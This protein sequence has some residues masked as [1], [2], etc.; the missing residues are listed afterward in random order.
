SVSGTGTIS[1][2][3]LVYTNP[4]PGVGKVRLVVN[5]A[6]S[7][8]SVVQLDLVSNTTLTATG[9]AT[10]PAR[11][12]AYSAG[13]NLPLNT[14]RVEA[15]TTLL[16]AGNALNLGAAPRAVA[17]ALPTSGPTAGVLYTGVSQKIDGAGKVA[18]DVGVLPGF[19]YYSVRLKL[20]ASATVGAV[21]DGVSLD[22][23]FRAAVRGRGGDEVL[24]SA[25]FSIGK[26]EVR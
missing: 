19:V 24:S 10:I 13:M 2:H 8:A 25:D 4:Q 9:S 12:G 6:A 16:V 5:Q 20:P 3:G 17:A 11:G 14:S 26:L 1:V 22:Q 7:S 21:F 23:R 15:D 18:G